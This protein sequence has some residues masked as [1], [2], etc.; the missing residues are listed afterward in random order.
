MLNS[1]LHD[2]EIFL[3]RM[4][5]P[6]SCTLLPTWFVLLPLPTGRDGRNR[7]L[8]QSWNYWC[9]Q[10]PSRRYIGI[11]QIP[12]KMRCT[13]TPPCIAIRK[14]G[15]KVGSKVSLF[16]AGRIHFHGQPVGPCCTTRYENRK[17]FTKILF[18]NPSPSAHVRSSILPP[19]SLPIPS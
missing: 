8:K 5:M 1:C 14:F 4:H 11:K 12:R 16:A 13:L 15:S 17:R 10:H 7:G 9:R 18:K 19:V 2:E 3:L 6:L